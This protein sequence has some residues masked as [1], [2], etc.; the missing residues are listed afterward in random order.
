MFEVLLL[1]MAVVKKA[2]LIVSHLML[3]LGHEHPPSSSYTG[4]SCLVFIDVSVSVHAIATCRGCCA[5]HNFTMLPGHQGIPNIQAYL[6]TEQFEI[7][8]ALSSELTEMYGANM[9]LPNVHHRA[10]CTH[11]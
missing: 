8:A 2:G 11:V 9:L 3:Q 10:G 6:D 1:V 5:E 4:A 7:G